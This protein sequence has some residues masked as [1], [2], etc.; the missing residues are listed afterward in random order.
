LYVSHLIFE[1][2]LTR[3]QGELAHCASKR[4]YRWTNKRDFVRQIAKHERRMRVLR[5][6]FARKHQLAVEAQRR[7]TGTEPPPNKRQK[8][9]RK[10]GLHSNLHGNS[11][12]LPY[13]SGRQHHYISESHRTFW[14]FDDLPGD[15][16]PAQKPA[17][18]DSEEE[19]DG[20]AEEMD[21]E[22]D[23]ALRVS[24]L[25]FASY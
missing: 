3:M 22:T 9:R 16:A 18:E 24:L 10:R 8:T 25:L 23:P 7:L 14:K 4:M 2:F 1:T 6:I 15:V 12:P 17:E 20:I 5:R 21:V 19:D 11:D 13:S